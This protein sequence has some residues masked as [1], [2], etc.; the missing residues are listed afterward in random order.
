MTFPHTPIQVPFLHKPKQYAQVNVLTR[1][2]HVCGRRRAANFIHHIKHGWLLQLRSFA[3]LSLHGRRPPCSCQGS[4]TRSF[5]LVLI[6]FAVARYCCGCFLGRTAWL[7]VECRT[8]ESSIHRR[9]HSRRSHHLGGGLTWTA[10]LV[11]TRARVFQ[12]G[13]DRDN[14]VSKVMSPCWTSCNCTQ[15]ALWNVL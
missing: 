13:D 1:L 4:H 11:R 7:L 6:C 8:A 14:S 5:S 9:F 10:D 2:Q 12:A 3:R 15:R